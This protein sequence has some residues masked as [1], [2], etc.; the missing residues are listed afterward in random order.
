MGLKE[1]VI[2]AIAKTLDVGENEI[3]EDKTLYDSIGVDSTEMVELAVALG[4][5][6]EI[7]IEANEI[8]KNSTP[9]EIVTVIENKKS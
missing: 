1:E 8:G 5:Q 7:R 6:F 2:S 4:K 3:V 9:Q